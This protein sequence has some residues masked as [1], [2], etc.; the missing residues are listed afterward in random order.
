MKYF[1]NVIEGVESGKASASGDEL[2]CSGCGEASLDGLSMYLP[3]LLH[4]SAQ[5]Q[6][7]I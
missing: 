4:V 3:Q 2:D 1:C 7:P 6:R 5:L